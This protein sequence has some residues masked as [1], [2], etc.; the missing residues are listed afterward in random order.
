MHAYIS[1]F[2]RRE[3]A[4]I[5]HHG[6]DRSRSPSLAPSPAPRATISRK[7]GPRTPA[8]RKPGLALR[9]APDQPDLLAPDL[10]A[11]VDAEPGP[12]PAP[13]P[14]AAEPP[15]DT[16]WAASRDEPAPTRNWLAIDE[17]I[18]LFENDARARGRVLRKVESRS[19]AAALV[20]WCQRQVEAGELPPRMTFDLVRDE[21]LEMCDSRGF[22]PASWPSVGRYFTKLTGGK[23]Y[24]PA[25][26]ERTGLRTAK[27]RYYTIPPRLAAAPLRWAA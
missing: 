11:G 9:F 15:T 1:R 6:P 5:R 13:K 10:F 8:P 27:V 20:E 22:L 7:P 16:R 23:K 24:F 3:S 4:H 12:L 14:A 19:I 21:Y 18:R 2:W 26:D 17:Q 25:L